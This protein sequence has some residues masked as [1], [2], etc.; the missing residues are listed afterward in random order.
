MRLSLCLSLEQQQ[1]PF[2]GL[3]RKLLL[4]RLSDGSCSFGDVQDPREC[5][6]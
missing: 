5:A 1:Q 2:D 3:C 4:T 6:Q